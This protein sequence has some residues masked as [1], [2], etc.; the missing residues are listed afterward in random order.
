MSEKLFFGLTYVFLVATG[1]KLIFDS[2]T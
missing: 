2:L 1:A